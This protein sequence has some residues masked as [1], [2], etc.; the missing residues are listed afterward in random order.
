MTPSGGVV[1]FCLASSAL[2]TSQH[3]FSNAT[4]KEQARLRAETKFGDFN[5]KPWTALTLKLKRIEIV[6]LSPLI[7][8][9]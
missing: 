8:I 4:D 9:L 1:D 2:N 7:R 5:A 6:E 3:R